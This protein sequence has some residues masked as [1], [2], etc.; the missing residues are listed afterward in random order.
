MSFLSERDTQ[1][2]KVMDSYFTFNENLRERRHNKYAV[3]IFL[4]PMLDSII[5][6]F[7]ERFDPI[8]N[9]ISSHISLVFPFETNAPLD[10]LAGRIRMEADK[11][12][13]IPIELDS[14]G[15]FYPAAPIIYWSLKK[16][17][18]LNE[19]YFRLYAQLGL[20]IPYKNYVPHVTIA[21]EISAHRV[22]I[23][24]DKIVSYLAEEK[25]FAGTIDLI[26]PL[27]NNRWV[28]VRTFSFSGSSDH[29]LTI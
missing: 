2:E 14:I 4:P 3:V 7:R 15:D 20:P 12:P 28:S 10:E 1:R 8:H 6:P 11:Q 22:V 5:A 18:Q 25:F 17:N 13:S 24:K 21:R 19:L 23:V 29:P 16:N 9:Q 26:M 27:M